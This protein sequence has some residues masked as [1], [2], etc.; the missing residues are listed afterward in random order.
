M[1]NFDDYDDDPYFWRFRRTTPKK[2]KG[3]IRA[4]TKKFGNQWWGVRWLEA[5]EKFGPAKR[6]ARGRSYARKGQVLELQF[7]PGLISATVQGSRDTPYEVEIILERL[8]P[9]IEEN[10]LHD[11]HTQPIYSATLLTGEVHPDVENLFRKYDFPLF[12]TKLEGRDASCSCP[13]DGNPCKHIAAVYYLISEELE[14]DPFLL[15]HLRG[16]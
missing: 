3:G 1:N 8:P 9:E 4:Q 10:I 12:P 6:V 15:L 13:D 7:A 5:I 11:L 14:R 2:V 16:I